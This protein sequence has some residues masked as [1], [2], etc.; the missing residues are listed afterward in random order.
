MSG[1]YSANAGGILVS[2][3]TV[4]AV[5]TNDEVDRHIY[6]L[7]Y[8][9]ATYLN[10]K[11]RSTSIQNAALQVLGGAPQ[12]CEIQATPVPAPSP[13]GYFATDI[14]VNNGNDRALTVGISPDTTYFPQNDPNLYYVLDLQDLSLIVTV[15]QLYNQVNN[16]AASESILDAAFSALKAASD[17]LEDRAERQG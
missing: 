11:A 16:K 4:P 17:Q 5:P 6:L 15:L 12:P 13:A 1:G 8:Q 10:D 14:R 2:G 7:I 3:D 9:L